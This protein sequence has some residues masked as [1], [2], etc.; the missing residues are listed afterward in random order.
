ML[1]LTTEISQYNGNKLI[2]ITYNGESIF[3]KGYSEIKAE[4]L[5]NIKDTSAKFLS[6]IL[7]GR[8]PASLY[9][10]LVNMVDGLV[11]VADTN[12]EDTKVIEDRI[13]CL[14]ELLMTED[15]MQYKDQLKEL[16][17]NYI[18]IERDDNKFCYIFTDWDVVDAFDEI[19]IESN[20]YE[21][22]KL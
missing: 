6:M 11:V 5:Q 12:E 7:G 15:V 2:Q 13:G 9:S 21:Y 4:D 19:Q 18:G 10:D 3:Y 1:K 8:I 17:Y 16:G 22:N 20:M 14:N